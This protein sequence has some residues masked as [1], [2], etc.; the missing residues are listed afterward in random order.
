MTKIDRKEPPLPL[1]DQARGIWDR[2]VQDASDSEILADCDHFLLARYCKLQSEIIDLYTFEREHPDKWH[3]VARAKNGQPMTVK[4]PQLQ[5]LEKIEP[6]LLP[7]ERALGFSTSSRKRNG[8]IKDGKNS[9]KK[10]ISLFSR[11]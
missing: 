6:Q 7:M 3:I 4:S 1:D 8:K 11:E 10:S 2:L 5:R 9:V